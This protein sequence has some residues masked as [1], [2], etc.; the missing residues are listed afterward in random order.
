MKTK[1]I[2]TAILAALML[3]TTFVSCSR[4]DQFRPP[5]TDAPTGEQTTAAGQPDVNHPTETNL[6][7]TNPN[8][9]DVTDTT[10]PPDIPVVTPPVSGGES[11]KITGNP[12]EGWTAE[13][14]YASFMEDQE[15]SVYNNVND[16]FG[17]TP[18]YVIL[19]GQ[20][21]GAMFSKL[22]GQV[23]TICKDPLCDHENCIFS[24]LVFFKS[25][26][27]VDDR[28]YILLEGFKGDV[29][30]SSL[31][32]FDLLM[33]DAKLVYTWKEMDC[34]SEVYVYRDK[35]YYDAEI[36]FDDGQYRNITMVYDI[37][38]ETVSPLR[39]ESVRYV[40][41]W[42]RGVYEWYGREDGSLWRYH[43]DTGEDEE[44]ISTAYLN[45]E[46]GELGFHF[47]GSVDQAVYVQKELSTGAWSRILRYDM[48]TG[49]L[50][51]MDGS[52]TFIYDGNFYQ[53]VSHRVDAY[54]DDPHYEYYQ[55]PENL[56]SVGGTMWGGKWYRYDMQ[57]GER[58]VILDLRTDDIP[59]NLDEFLF[60]DGKYVMVQYQ[61]Y[62]DFPNVYSPT[63]PLWATSERYVVV[64]LETGTAYELGVDLSSQSY[65]K[66]LEKHEKHER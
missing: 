32:S 62:K 7:E 53:G 49:Q 36:K 38:E 3:A 10:M 21:G 11:D 1:R 59:D 9:G 16:V 23:V 63:L 43:L 19:N 24:N 22:T 8:G 65:H 34:P 40:V 42:H 44:V 46:E 57:T 48:E 12:Y 13:E 4:R 54:K 41:S 29:F 20:Y 15:R 47:T 26:Q 55:N 31:Y 28:C 50:Q 17:N 45:R 52:T 6:T 61:T 35:I 2:I 39:E 18:Y 27:V 25:C 58:E 66:W 64:N 60:L 56:T 33:N 37:K 5:E 51:E 30:T 14:L